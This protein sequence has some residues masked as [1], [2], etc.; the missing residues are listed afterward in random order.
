M[1][2]DYLE[3]IKIKFLE[4]IVGI[5]SATKFFKKYNNLL[6]YKDYEEIVK[7]MNIFLKEKDVKKK[8]IYY[9]PSYL[10]LSY[11]NSHLN[12]YN[13]QIQQLNF[14]KY[15]IQKIAEENNFQFIDGT[16]KF[17]E[18]HIINKIFF[19]ALPTHF[20]EKGYEMLAEDLYEKIIK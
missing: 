4:G 20:N 16:K 8:Y 1:K 7:K 12:N 17:N 6:N 13:N 5:N 15:Q 9:I 3:I 19:Y 11:T 10:R 2:K 14:L 18:E